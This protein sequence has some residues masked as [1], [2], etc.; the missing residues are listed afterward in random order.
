MQESIR[1]FIA[2]D[3]DNEAVLKKIMDM[4]GVIAKAGAD[5]KFVEPKNIHV[6]VR[7]LG[8]INASM[9]E[10]NFMKKCGKFNLHHSPLKFVG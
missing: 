3:I 2:F 9:V 4:Q 7:F 5:V 10:K 8:D 1:S 6:T